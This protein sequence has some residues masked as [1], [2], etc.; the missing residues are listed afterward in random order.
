MAIFNR[1]KKKRGGGM[2]PV[3]AGAIGLVVIASA[4]ALR[5]AAAPSPRD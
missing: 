2:S 3:K 5:S 4:G 1:S